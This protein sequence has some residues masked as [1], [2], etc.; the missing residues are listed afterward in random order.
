MIFQNRKHAGHLLAKKLDGFKGK[1]NIVLAL[2]RGGV[3]VAAEIAAALDSPLEVLVVRKIGAQED[4]DLAVG[5]LCESSEPLW[6]EYFLSRFDLKP[7]DISEAVSFEKDRIRQQIEI[8]RDGRPLPNLKGKNIILVDD[9]LATGMTMSAAIGYLRQ[10][11]VADIVI[12]VPVAA[13]SAIRKLRNQVA[14]A[15]ALE[16]RVDLNSVG[17]WYQDF[18]QVSNQEVLRLLK[19]NHQQATVLR[20]LDPSNQLDEAIE[21][22]MIA[23]RKDADLDGLIQSLKNNR[24]V[25]L[26]ESSHGT[27]EFYEMRM[28]ISQRLIAEHG[29]KFIAV[30]GDWPDASRLHQYIQTGAGGSAKAVLLRNHRWPTWMWANQ[31]TIHLAEWMRKHQAGF[32]GL[33][34]YSLFESM[35]EVIGYIKKTEP[36]QLA[37]FEKR[38]S[39]FDPF[40]GDEIAYARSLLQYAPGCE[41]EVL[42]NLKVLLSRRID[43]S[44][45]D[46]DALF[47]SQ[48]NAITVANAESYYRAML[49][50]DA[51][52][53]NIRDSHMLDTLDRLLERGGEGAKAVVW[54]HNSHIGDYRA[55]DM[56]AAG[57]V[58]LGGLARQNYG[59]DNVAL[60]GFG[61]YDG[62]VLAAAAWGRPE[63]VMSLPPAIPESYEH[64]FHK[65]A[66]KHHLNEFYILLE[67][68]THSPFA[69]P[70]GHRA[71]GVVYDP[72]HELRGNY[73]PTELSKRYDA[74]VFIDHTQALHSLHSVFATGEVPE[75]WPSGQ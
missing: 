48:Q 29:F 36:N 28:R 21:N 42:Q 38:Y 56:E 31:E 71:V 45:K 50:G 75:T 63:Q 65:V 20:N 27:K 43:E 68:R 24:V 40:A 7:S 17:Y 72:R 11:S 46:S 64:Y 70:R 60:V 66:V 37:D 59:S 69:K 13:T 73:V 61:T 41:R 23:I 57:Y 5:A 67:D 74:F 52:S 39:C 3:P 49:S 62:E 47:N 34:I 1:N 8:F 14:A 26:G 30:E 9:G 16:E 33:D 25:M 12:A 58:N 10:K 54:A 19:K 55:T 51:S 32:Y 18:S 44:V 2:P 35:N 53:W 15:V 22:E 4:P 6:N